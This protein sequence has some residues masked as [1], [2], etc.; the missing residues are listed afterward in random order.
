MPTLL[1]L[2]ALQVFIT[3]TYGTASDNEMLTLWQLLVYLDLW[4]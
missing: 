2:V 1:L 4:T 3:A